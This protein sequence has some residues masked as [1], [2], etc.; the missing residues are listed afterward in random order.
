[1]SDNKRYYYL[2]LK[3]NFFDSEEMVYLESEKDGVKY[4]NFLLKLYCKS[5]KREG[6]LVLNE[7]V[8]YDTKMLAK[9]T[10]FSESFTKKALKKLENLGLIQ[11]LDDGTIFMSNIQEYIG[12]SSTEA[13]RKRIYRK[14]I[15]E[16][17]S[18]QMSGQMYDKRTPEIEIDKEIEKEID[19]IDRFRDRF[20][21]VT[22]RNAYIK[23]QSSINSFINSY[24]ATALGVVM[25]QIEHSNYLKSNADFEWVCNNL[26]NIANGKYRDRNQEADTEYEEPEYYID[27]RGYK[28]SVITK[29]ILL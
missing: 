28:R 15:E 21:E 3:E 18:G 29:E 20:K 7:L 25:E 27:D 9:V 12:K 13:D 2:K 6:R 22:G 4:S 16:E 17:K 23:N 8:P 10:R 1:M 19:D 14:K 24:G 26:S 5:L 11:R